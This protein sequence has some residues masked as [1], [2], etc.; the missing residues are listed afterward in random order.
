MEDVLVPPKPPKANTRMREPSRSCGGPGSRR[1]PVIVVPG[2]GRSGI[3]SRALRNRLQR[4]EFEVYFLPLPYYGLGDPVKT[5]HFL[6]R[7]LDE[8]KVLLSA[9]RL[10]VIC[11]GGSGLIMRYCLEE[12]GR[13]RYLERVIFL[14]TMMRGTY[15]LFYLPLF[16]A[17]RQVM[18][19]SS[20]MRELNAEAPPPLAADRYVS[21][22]SRYGTFFAPGGSGYLPGIRNVKVDW[23]CPN[24]DLSRSRRVLTLLLDALGEGAG[25]GE[26]AAPGGWGRRPPREAAAADRGQPK[27]P[28][29]LVARGRSHLEKGC[30]D[31]AIHDLNAAIR[32]KPDLPEAYFLRAMALRRKVRYDENPIHNRSIL[33]L[34]RTIRLKPGYAEAYYERGVCHALLGDWDEAVSDWNHALI[35]NRDYHAAYLARGLARSKAGNGRGA[36]EDFRE[37]LRLHPDNQDA[38]RMISDLEPGG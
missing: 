22:Y 34:S 11:Q 38:L 15:R 7:R 23:L 29:A 18:P 5:A 10:D 21:V 8:F 26:G 25:T 12:L 13:N 35:L 2:L 33:D 27:D 3:S 17:P 30:W 6:G 28:E 1:N 31:L 19:V 9:G 16:K 20:F 24:P 32:H 4:L 14:G 36:L 37:V